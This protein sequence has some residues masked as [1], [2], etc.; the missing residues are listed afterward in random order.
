M[1]LSVGRIY[2]PS[3]NRPLPRICASGSPHFCVAACTIGGTLQGS[4]RRIPPHSTTSSLPGQPTW[5]PLM[6]PSKEWAASG[7]Q[8]NPPTLG[9]RRGASCRPW[10]GATHFLLPSNS[11]LSRLPTLAAA[12]PTPTSSLLVLSPLRPCSRQLLHSILTRCSLAPIIHRPSHGLISA[13][14]QQ[15]PPQR[16]SYG[17]KG[18]LHGTTAS[19]PVQPMSRARRIRRPIFV[20]VVSTSPTPTF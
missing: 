2:S 10:P 20:L 14:R 11:N 8:L 13:R 6:P 12:S 15:L 1:A 18:Y 19:N 7:Y 3:S 5:V 16:F 9:Q 17:S 4:W